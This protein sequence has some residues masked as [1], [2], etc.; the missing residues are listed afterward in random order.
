MVITSASHAQKN[1]VVDPD[2]SERTLKG[3]FN[4][5]KVSGGIDLYIS[6]SDK[7][8]VAVSAATDKL[9][10][11]IKTVIENGTLNIFYEGD[12][13]WKK[14]DRKLRVYISCTELKKIDG[15]G[16]CDIVVAGT[17]TVSMLELGLTGACDF[18]GKVKV[19]T[20]KLNLT[21]ASDASISG[22]ANTVDI[23]CSG[24]SD[25][26]GYNLVTDVCNA[27]ATGASDI[28]IT[29]NKELTAYAKGASD[30]KYKGNA[31]IK[32]MNNRGASSIS[33]SNK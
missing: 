12:K 5:I 28:Y 13:I 2:A 17:M 25:F 8:A 9:K 30:I 26:K 10:T 14:R 32:E 22:T 6:Q 21:G 11:G 18:K 1:I 16:A 19:N 27:K 24:A 7:I 31:L 15:K 20:L 3:N 23:E 29:V 33:R 4:A